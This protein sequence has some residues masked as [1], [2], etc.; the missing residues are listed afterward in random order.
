VDEKKYNYYLTKCP[1]LARKPLAEKITK[2]CKAGWC[3]A[4]AEQAALMLI[5]H[6]RMGTIHSVINAVKHNAN[7]VK[8]VM[9]NAVS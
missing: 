8:D 6:K 2:Y 9:R 1:D 5:V 7:M 3:P 4:Q